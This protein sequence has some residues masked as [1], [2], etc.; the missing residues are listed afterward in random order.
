VRI[1][2]HHRTQAE[3][4]QGVHIAELVSA[5]ESL[6]HEVELASLVAKKPTDAKPK[7]KPA[8]S[9]E[10]NKT[11]E[12]EHIAKRI[13]RRVPYFYEALQCGYNLVAFPWLLKKVLSSK[14][15]FIYERYSLFNFAGVAVAALTSR[16]IILEVNSPLALEQHR[17]KEIRAWRFSA[18]MERLVCNS[19]TKVVV[20][21]SPLRRILEESGV[22][23]EKLAVLPNGV[24]LSSFTNPIVNPDDLRRKYQLEG[25]TVIGF[26]GW[27]RSW[28]GIDLLIDAFAQAKLSD[29]RAALMLI[30]DGPERENLRKQVRQLGLE[31]HVIF[32]GAVTHREIPSYVALLDVAVQPA[33]N[34]YC[35]PMKILEYMGLGKAIV[36]PRQENIQELLEEGREALMFAGR[37]RDGLARALTELIDHP[38]KRSKLGSAAR[39]AIDTRGLLWTRNAQAVIDMAFPGVPVSDED[40]QE[41]D[42]AQ[43]GESLPAPPPNGA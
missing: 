26:V 24:N 11:E 40:W 3:D 8:A 17:E 25:R 37:D 14:P 38:E 36:G 5:L 34:E 10:S 13:S 19:A 29:K 4:A 32:T 33:A 6:G 28:H 42:G 12:K 35:C 18:W 43:A 23:R 1:L 30:G 7:K 9:T 20:V 39:Q 22:R 21:S 31:E 27:F 41:R 16:P 15:D 2:Y